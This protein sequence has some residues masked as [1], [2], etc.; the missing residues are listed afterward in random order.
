MA[1]NIYMKKNRVEALKYRAEHCCCKYCGS[2][3]ELRRIV[4]S[5]FEDAR[6]ELFCTSCD[7]IEYGV[8][9]EIYQS[10]S[11][12]VDTLKF[13]HFP[14]LSQNEQTRKMNIAKVCDIMSWMCQNLGFANEH[15]FQVP[16]KMNRA[17]LGETLILTE[18]E[19]NELL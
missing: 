12:F 13:N 10:A 9:E 8:E 17:I 14:E 16:I 2:P 3:L 15:G 5:D 1:E 19:L 11:Y 18:E 7:R 6:I 4:F